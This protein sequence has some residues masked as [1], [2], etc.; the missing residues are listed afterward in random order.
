[1]IICVSKQ[2]PAWASA[3]VLTPK[4]NALLVSFQLISP[5][6]RC[7]KTWHL[8]LTPSLPSHRGHRHGQLLQFLSREPVYV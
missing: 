3:P 2:G 5:M 6:N 1:P 4:A 7:V 8:S